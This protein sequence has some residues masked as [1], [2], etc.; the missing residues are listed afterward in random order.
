MAT[1][2][3]TDFENDID[4][5]IA[6]NSNLSTLAANT[7]ATAEW[8]LWRSIIASF[9][10]LFS[11]QVDKSFA[12][13]NQFALSK[14][15]GTRQWYKQMVLD[16]AVAFPSQIIRVSVKESEPSQYPPSVIIK[17]ANDDGS[18]RTSAVNVGDL[19]DLKDVVNIKKVVGTN[20][21]V[22]SQIADY[23]SISIKATNNGSTTLEADTIQAVKDYLLQLPFDYNFSQA[24]L[25]AY[26]L[27]N[28]NGLIDV[29]ITSLSVDFGL[30]MQVVTTND[31]ASFAG[32]FELAKVSGV[33]Q[34]F[35]TII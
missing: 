24:T 26:L 21:Y 18:G 34:I 30:G 4:A 32:Y 15:V 22:I 10:W 5:G 6:A 28:V 3:I 12:E 8:K 27:N 14:I 1:K 9:A 25:I 2:T 11:K 13:L 31:I 29:E 35:I 17:V 19:L 23:L 16:W 33:E 20:V 7:S